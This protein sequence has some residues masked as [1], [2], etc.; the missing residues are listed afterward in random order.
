MNL[1]RQGPLGRVT[2]ALSRTAPNRSIFVPIFRSEVWHA[3]LG[4]RRAR[5]SSV[6]LPSLRSRQGAPMMGLCRSGR[7]RRHRGAN[8]AVPQS[9]MRRSPQCRRSCRRRSCRS[10]NRRRH[11]FLDISTR[12][13]CCSTHR[14]ALA[15]ALRPSPPRAPRAPSRPTQ[16]ACP[17]QLSDAADLDDADARQRYPPKLCSS[18]LTCRPADCQPN[19]APRLA[20]PIAGR[21]PA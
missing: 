15:L 14:H 2:F 8:L 18:R 11:L 4:M 21:V 6:T 20:R 5:R 3:G 9:P 12:G 19:P 7:P 17:C 16:G 10:C 1:I 13:T